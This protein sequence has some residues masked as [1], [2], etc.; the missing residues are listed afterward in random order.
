MSS[1]HQSGFTI[2]ELLIVIVVIAILAAL[3]IVAYR[4]IQDR[5]NNSSAQ[6]AAQQVATKLKV[7]FVENETYPSSLSSV[8]ITD[9][10]STTY[11]YS[12]NNA[13]SP[14]TFCITA[15]TNGRSYYINNTS[16][17]SPA[18]GGCAGHGQGG[19]PAI[20]N[21][22]VN[23][24]IETNTTGMAYR[25]FG[26]G[27]GAGTNTRPTSGGFSGDAFM[28]KT[29]TASPTAGGAVD[30]GFNTAIY[31]ASESLTYAGSCYFRTSRSGVRVKAYLS[32]LNSSN[33]GISSSHGSVVTLPSN[34]WGRVNVSGV[35]AAG[36]AGVR[37]VCATAWAEPWQP[38]DTL[39]GDA[40]MIT[41]GSA[42]YNYADGDSPNWVW[43]GTPH[44]STS[45]GPLL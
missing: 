12:V 33:G 19:Q 9:S 18:Q 28:R 37:L 14:K 36:T 17:A 30:T 34:T 31:P 11:Q 4:G 35:S 45:T 10:E 41:E 6:S 44:S 25:Y 22:V 8:G 5:A 38:G 42:L 39:D 15:T 43:S 27:G 23:P 26:D 20:T 7:A 13:T 24:S 40:F 29:W 16:T 32:W 3:S 2:V 1:K 21:I